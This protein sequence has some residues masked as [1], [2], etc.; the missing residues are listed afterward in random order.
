MGRISPPSMEGETRGLLAIS[1]APAK[2]TETLPGLSYHERAL[3]RFLALALPLV[4]LV[5]AG[6]H[7]AVEAL[8]LDTPDR[9]PATHLLALWGLE[10]VGLVA[11]FAL[12][13]ERTW[14][15]WLAGLAAAWGAWIF[16]GPVLYLTVA[17]TAGAGRTD[18]DSLL[19]AWLVIYTVCGV[20][21]ATV[22]AGARP[23]EPA[24][25]AATVHRLDQ[26]TEREEPRE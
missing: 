9:L 13:R 12:V 10:T 22:A 1:V 18:W 16:R 14:N 26:R 15:R 5:L 11:L 19:F 17:G 3:P 2:T 6:S 21:M 24:R 7:F 25:P 4:L 8:G 20:A 23:A